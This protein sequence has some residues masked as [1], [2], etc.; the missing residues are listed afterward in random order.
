[1]GRPQK[2]F[3]VEVRRGRKGAASPHQAAAPKPLK[4]KE[5]PAAAVA[6]RQPVAP[7]PQPAPRRILDAI[8][9]LPTPVEVEIEEAHLAKPRRGRPPKSANAATPRKPGRPRRN[10]VRDTAIAV[11]T[12]VLSSG[13]TTVAAVASAE[14]AT[15]AAPAA[16]TSWKHA[17]KTELR[18][19]AP[20]ANGRASNPVQTSTHGHVSHVDRA[21]A[22]A[23]LPRGERWKRR[24]PK[25]LW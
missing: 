19:Q 3:T 1:V 21:E 13:T 4:T 12:A 17:T 8:E 15:G 7:A 23:G 18:A 20:S 14:T 11:E 6:E 16:Q 25:V 22:A 9:P 2:P 10:P 24:V 5:R